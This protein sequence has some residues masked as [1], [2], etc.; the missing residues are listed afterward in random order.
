[1]AVVSIVIAIRVSLRYMMD[2]VAL[3]RYFD[4]IF[5]CR[6]VERESMLM[7]ENI[8]ECGKMLKNKFC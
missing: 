7:Q 2:L 3:K 8:E 1:M 6:Y 4:F 5:A